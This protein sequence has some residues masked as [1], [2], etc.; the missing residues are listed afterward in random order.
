MVKRDEK[1]ASFEKQLAELQTIV[2][3]LESGE[4]ELEPSLALFERGVV[5]YKQLKGRLQEA[6]TR[7]EKL[8]YELEGAARTTNADDDVDEDSDEEEAADDITGP[9]GGTNPDD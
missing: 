7:V 1:S 2:D 5:L 9:A 3:R 4:V 6:E 8:I